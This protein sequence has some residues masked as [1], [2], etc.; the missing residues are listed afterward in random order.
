[1]IRNPSN[2]QRRCKDV[3]T[4]IF[5]ECFQHWDEPNSNF[6]FLEGVN[7]RSEMCRIDFSFSKLQTLRKASSLFHDDW[8]VYLKN[9]IDSRRIK[10]LALFLVMIDKP[11][12]VLWE[13]AE[14][15]SLL[16][17]LLAGL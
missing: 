4:V 6:S 3:E 14:R 1:M 17:S 7:Q 10:Q 8:L 5:T 9:M 12:N 13:E 2:L 11:S 15:K 16:Y